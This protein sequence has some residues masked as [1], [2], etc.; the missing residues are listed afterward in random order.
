M[1]TARLDYEKCEAV[2]HEVRDSWTA[3]LLS[4][5]ADDLA[6]RLGPPDGVRADGDRY[7]LAVSRTGACYELLVGADG[8]FGEGSLPPRECGLPDP[9]KP[10]GPPAKRSS[11]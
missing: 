6:S 5:R 7:W 4:N 11:E 2:Y 8:S 9:P 10:I 1:G 3:R